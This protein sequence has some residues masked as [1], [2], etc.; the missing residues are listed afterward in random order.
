MPTL[1]RVLNIEKTVKEICTV[2]IPVPAADGTVLPSSP[3]PPAR[4]EPARVVDDG[5]IRMGSFSP[6]FPASCGT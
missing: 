4:A 6:L 3:L 5:K 2:K 1:S